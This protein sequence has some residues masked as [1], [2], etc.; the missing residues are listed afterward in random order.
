MF[1]CYKYA[2]Y[3]ECLSDKES[4]CIFSLKRLPKIEELFLNRIV[5]SELLEQKVNFFFFGN[6][7]GDI[8]ATISKRFRYCSIKEANRN[9]IIENNGEL[10]VFIALLSEVTSDSVDDFIK[11][12]SLTPYSF[13]ASYD[14]TTLS[15]LIAKFFTKSEEEVKKE[16]FFLNMIEPTPSIRDTGV[17][18]IVSRK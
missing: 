13:I 5:D 7:A 2:Q 14:M 18:K 8:C 1:Y 16:G 12:N 9:T 10:N 11:G 4:Q 17:V 6:T 3:L 15:T